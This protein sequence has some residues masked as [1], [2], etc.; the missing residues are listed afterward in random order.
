MLVLFL[1]LMFLPACTPS[2]T[3][4]TEYTLFIE[5]MGRGD[6]TPAPWVAHEYSLWGMDTQVITVEPA[7]GW[8]FNR[9]G[10]SPCIMDDMQNLGN[11]K[12]QVAMDRSRYITVAFD[13]F[14]SEL[15]DLNRPN[16]IAQDREGFF[17]V[18][19]KYNNRIQILDE[20]LQVLDSWEFGEESDH[21]NPFNPWFVAVG[22]ELR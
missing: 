7:D 20:D 2:C 19:D 22:G 13:T 17:Y 5:Q 8:R 9:F 3:I 11:N 6:I 15:G 12:W 18:A 4:E 10:V 16:S 21:E 1:F 14:D